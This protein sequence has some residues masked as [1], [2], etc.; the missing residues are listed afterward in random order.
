MDPAESASEFIH[1]PDLLFYA[2]SSMERQRDCSRGHLIGPRKVP[3]RKAS[4]SPPVSSQ[5]EVIG[6]DGSLDAPSPES[7]D[8]A[9][10]P[11]SQF[12]RKLDYIGLK[13]VSRLLCGGRR[14]HAYR[15]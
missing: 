2:E 3:A 7:R 10:A 14:V 5:R 4:N 6:T 8:D 15:T 9:V 12:G 11:F 1:D 13:H